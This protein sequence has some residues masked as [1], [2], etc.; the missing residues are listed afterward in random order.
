MA[1]KKLLLDLPLKLILTEEGASNFIS[2]KKNLKRIKLADNVEE[3]GKYF[4]LVSY[5]IFNDSNTFLIL[6]LSYLF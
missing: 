4:N 1:A 3:Y 6:I 2:H 5:E